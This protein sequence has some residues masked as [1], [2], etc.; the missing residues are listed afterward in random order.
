MRV[1][2]YLQSCLVLDRG[3]SRIAIDLGTRPQGSYDL[4]EVGT[5]DGVLYTHRHADHVDVAV[6]D[7]LVDRGVPLY[8]NADVCTALEGR[9]VTAVTDGQAL[10]V[11]AFGVVARDL[12]H[13]LMIDGTPG[14]P[15]TGFLIDDRLFHPGDGMHIDGLALDVL[16]VPLAGP[17]I[18]L[19]DAYRMVADLGPRT[20]IPIHY[21]LFVADPQRFAQACTLAEV[22]VLDP[23]ESTTLA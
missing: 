4:G 5:L 9:P 21:D 10:Q 20:V 2:K 16:A 1:T 18:S 6:V 14:P 13:C 11:G 23:G 3:D 7:A 12:D 19:H 8:G 17:S 15:N 22:V